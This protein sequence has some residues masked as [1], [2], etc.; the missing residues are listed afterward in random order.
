MDESSVYDDFPSAYFEEC[1]SSILLKIWSKAS[2]LLAT[3]NFG[4]DLTIQGKTVISM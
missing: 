3:A 1:A 2:A 4:R